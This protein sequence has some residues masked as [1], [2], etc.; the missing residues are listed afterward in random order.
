MIVN[1]VEAVHRN[2]KWMYGFGVVHQAM[3]YVKIRDIS[4]HPL[5]IQVKA[6][7]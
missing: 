2:F 1:L 6:M 5:L 7:R 4:P 3:T